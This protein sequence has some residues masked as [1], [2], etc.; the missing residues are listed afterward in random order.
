MSFRENTVK[1]VAT[2]GPSSNSKEM[3]KKLIT[4]GVDIFR[5]N[6]SHGNHKE[7]RD[8]LDGRGREP[9]SLLRMSAP[10]KWDRARQNGSESRETQCRCRQ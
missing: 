2:L 6:F 5:L 4:T 1:I 8:F 10:P 9:Y 7:K 3:L